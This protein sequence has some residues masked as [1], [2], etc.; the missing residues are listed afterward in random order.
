MYALDAGNGAVLW[1]ATTGFN[2]LSSPAVANGVVYV[3]SG[4]ES[5]Y[6]YSLGVVLGPI[7][8]KPS[9]L[10]PNYSLKVSA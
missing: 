3:G 6:A 7:R 10:H 5:I 1:T 8:P 9:S 4:D 2:I